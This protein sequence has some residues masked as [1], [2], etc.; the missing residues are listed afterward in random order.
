VYWVFSLAVA[1]GKQ[2]ASQAASQPPANSPAAEVH[3]LQAEVEEEVLQW[4]R[5]TPFQRSSP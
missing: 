4:G 3:V 5:A 1:A 2:A